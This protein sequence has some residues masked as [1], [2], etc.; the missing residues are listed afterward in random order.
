VRTEEIQPVTGS[1]VERF[2]GALTSE[3]R[4]PVSF[5]VGGRVEELYV[6]VGSRVRE[7]QPLGRLDR[8]PFEHGV[9]Q[10]RAAL[11]RVETSLEQARRDLARVEALG[12]A[13]TEEELESRRTAVEELEA[14]Q[15]GARSAVDE[16]ERQLEESEL[17][18]PY[19]GEVTRQLV[20]R[21]EVVSPGSP[22]YF[23]SGQG[24]R[25]EVELSVPEETAR[26]LA[27]EA[28]VSLT[29]PLSPELPLIEAEISSLSEHAA[30]P[31]GLFRLTLRLPQLDG[32]ERRLRPGLRV[33]AALPLYDGE[34]LLSVKSG[35]VLSRPDG[36]PIV[37]VVRGGKAREIPLSMVRV[38]EGRILARGP[39]EPGDRV[40]VSGHRALV[41]GEPVAEVRL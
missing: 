11:R 1:L 21:G 24:E 19:A 23:M 26:A 20:E 17:T 41:D 38:R 13:A 39:L 25:L 36:T 40:V 15:Q 5:T 3:D 16:A 8:R 35:A 30:R 9:E 31:G 32:A 7:G 6:A 14:R 2:S 18:A 12:E 27:P 10:A 33:S 4:G 37:F 34:E 29:F 22:I 28:P